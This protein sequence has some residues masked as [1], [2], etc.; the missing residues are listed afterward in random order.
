MVLSIE[1]PKSKF[2]YTREGEGMKYCNLKIIF[3]SLFFSIFSANAFDVG[4]GIHLSSYKG[5]NTNYVNLI[6]KY[7]FNSV[8]LDYHWSDVERTPGQYQ[9]ANPKLDS[10]IKTASSMGIKPLVIF[11]YGNIIYGGGKPITPEQRKA[12]AN[13]AV[14]TVKHLSP[15]VNTFEIWNEWHLEKPRTHSQSQESAEQYVMLV[16]EVYSAIKKASPATI[17]IAGS[18]NPTKPEEIA[19]EK[20][21]FNLGFLNYIDGISLHTYNNSF[22]SYLTPSES[23]VFVD[24][25]EHR[26]KNISGE[27][28]KIYITEI[29]IS[30]HYKNTIPQ[31][32]IAKFAFDYYKQAAD[33]SYIQGVWWYDFINDGDNKRDGEDNYGILNSDLTEK[34]IARSIKNLRE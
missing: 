15:S 28:K 34:P 18:F 29:G 27:Y 21:I 5:S 23:L 26:V 30:D 33:R 20:K 19:W 13:Y 10:F 8:R 12:F 32:D 1:G 14:W 7:G 31:S 22:S 3:I 16:K 24:K 9:S 2:N 4:V 11:D 25:M 17:V 6:K